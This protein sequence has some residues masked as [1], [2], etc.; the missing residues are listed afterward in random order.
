MDLGFAQAG[1][2]CRLAVDSDALALNVLAANLGIP[3]R[4]ADLSKATTQHLGIE[5]PTDLVFAGPPCQGFSTVGRRELYDPRNHLLLVAGSLSLSL[6]PKVIVIENVPGVRSG[7]HAVYWEALQEMF[8]IADYR[9]ADL[10]LDSAF[11]G[12]PQH[13][14]RAILIA[15]KGKEVTISIPTTSPSVLRMALQDA[16]EATD[17]R[18]RQ[19][20]QGTLDYAI[21]ERIG[22]GQKLS[23]VRG[24]NRAVHTWN[25]PS[26]F[27]RTSVHEREILESLISLRRRAKQRERG[28]A[29]PLTASR[30]S[31]EFGPTVAP[32]VDS[33]LT[34][35]YLRKV[36]ARFDLKHTFN[37]KY[38][39]LRWD[40]P[41]ATVDTRFGN[42]R[43]FLHPLEHRGFSV[44]EAARIQGFP[45]TFSLA[46]SEAERFRMIGN[47]VP[48]PLAK[49]VGMFIRKWLL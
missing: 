3:V 40:E 33:L 11:Y 16:S 27:G 39:R 17:H 5:Q 20:Q 34:K 41:S 22:M 9:T 21:A 15:W 26:V 10:T 38:R 4:T 35:G 25:I 47:A 13:R 36:G 7:D 48:P 8:R 19:L 46:G 23:N 31:K 14:K 37:G 28:D 32:V 43:Y 44:R 29:D 45:D 42:P 49:H 24:G 2:D 18:P 12:A 1:F 6:R 30:I